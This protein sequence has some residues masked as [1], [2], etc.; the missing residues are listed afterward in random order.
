MHGD[1][2]GMDR[3]AAGATLGAYPA[4]PAGAAEDPR[5]ASQLRTLSILYYVF[6]ALNLLPLLIGVAYAALG[7]GLLS[8]MAPAGRATPEEQTTSAMILLGLALALLLVAI[9]GGT[10]TV[11]TARRL[12]QRRGFTLCI[13]V[14]AIACMQIPLGT[15]LGVFTLIVLNRPSVKAM[16]EARA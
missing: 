5:D 8:G 3:T 1:P 14:A 10:L 2:T 9:I 16:F 12:R 7:I 13:V 11:M 15:L 4:A 6:A